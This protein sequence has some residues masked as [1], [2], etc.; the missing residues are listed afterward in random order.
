MFRRLVLALAVLA[1]VLAGC[2]LPR[3]AGDGFPVVICIHVRCYQDGLDS[4]K[5]FTTQPKMRSIL[6]ALRCI[7]QQFNP[8]RDPETLSGDSFHLTVVYSGGKEQHYHIKA[9]RYIRRAQE[10]WQQTDPKKLS[11]LT[12]LLA[13]LV[14]DE[15]PPLN[16]RSEGVLFRNLQHKT[17]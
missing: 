4:G 9:D 16:H 3:P 2:R 13:Q 14:T 10:P 12:N 5:V 8:E 15:Y 7:G 11:R 1:A 17:T 6:N